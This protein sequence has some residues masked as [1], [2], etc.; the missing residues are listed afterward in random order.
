M[1]GVSENYHGWNS[2]LGKTQCKPVRPGSLSRRRHWRGHLFPSPSPQQTPKACSST[3][4]RQD[5]RA[6]FRENIQQVSLAELQVAR[7]LRQVRVLSQHPVEDGSARVGVRVLREKV[8]M[9]DARQSRYL[10]P[11]QQRSLSQPTY[12]AAERQPA[13]C[14]LLPHLP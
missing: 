5:W 3:A 7:S 8:G 4:C 14:Q 10:S 12:L 2:T 13:I 6:T 9:E 11:A 1:S